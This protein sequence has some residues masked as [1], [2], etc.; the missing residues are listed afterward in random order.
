MMVD[1]AGRVLI[2]SI[3][4]SSAICVAIPVSY[5]SYGET[6]SP[7]P[8]YW[9]KISYH[10]IDVSNSGE[11][12]GVVVL[13]GHRVINFD[14]RP[15]FESTQGL[16]A[17][18]HDLPA[19]FQAFG[20]LNVG[21]SLNSRFDGLKVHLV[22]AL[23]HYEYALNFL[24][25]LG[26]WSG[27]LRWLG[28]CSLFERSALCV[29]LTL[30]AHGERLNWDSQHMVLAGRGDLCRSRE[31]GTQVFRRIIDRDHY[32]EILGLG[33]ARRGLRGS[34]AGGAHQGLISDFR[35]MPFKN[36]VRQSVDRH[37]RRFAQLHLHDVGLVDPNFGS[38]NGH[39]GQ[40]HERAAGSVLNADHHGF[41]FADGKI[42][43]NAIERCNVL[44]LAKNICQL[45]QGGVCL[46]N[47]ARAG[48]FLRLHL[49]ELGFRF[50]ESSGGDI[51]SGL[52][53][54]E[55]RL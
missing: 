54:V 16:E 45:V 36:L 37:F 43:H 48:G 39:V 5:P 22:A 46:R 31:A 20:D 28:F 13:L 34:H 15:N 23:V 1:V 32:F 10:A 9:T 35:H 52:F 47:A 8:Q 11:L 19:F 21:R 30:G 53:Y 4:V 25:A 3:V 38:W 27:G 26:V 24:F 49:R 33:G 6:K 44:G 55:I 17:A 29:Q 14:L 18:G 7:V 12:L 50:L 42:G 51:V 2:G 41:T 40:G